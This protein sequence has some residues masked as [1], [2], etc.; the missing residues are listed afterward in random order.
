MR[1]ERMRVEL[2]P[3]KEMDAA[4]STNMEEHT[5]VRLPNRARLYYNPSEAWD[6]I[7]LIVRGAKDKKLRIRQ[8]FKKDIASITDRSRLDHVGFVTTK[9]YT[10]IV[11]K[12]NNKADN[13]W[14]SED[15]ETVVIGCDPEFVIVGDNGQAVYAD[16]VLGANG[17]NKWDKLGSDGPCAEI[18]PDP[19]E[20]IEVLIK[21]IRSLLTSNKS[22]VINNYRWI[23]GARYKHPSM[24]KGFN[25]GGHI[26]LGKPA[27]VVKPEDGAKQDLYSCQRAITRILDEIV[28]IPMIRFDTPTPAERR[29]EYGGFGD[30]RI[31]G[32]QKVEWRVPSGIWLV[33]PTF[34]RAVLSVTKAV[35]EEIW[36][37]YKDR[38]LSDAF[39]IQKGTSD[40]IYGSFGCMSDEKARSILNNS[41]IK[42]VSDQHVANIHA[43]YKKMSTYHKYKEQIDLFVKLCMSKKHPVGEKYLELRDGWVNNKQ[44]PL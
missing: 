41:S 8:A 20:D 19:S 38:D 25:I 31:K 16:T 11:N 12:N 4:A 29:K 37:R 32:P 33:H 27:D 2:R 14:V 17:N 1:E 39:M 35:T 13:V 15:T 22:E 9:T 40:N 10:A 26:H 7:Y 21:N 30:V 43:L 18:R 44:L 36:K 28:G 34:S 24:A 6:K 5:F 3:S 23:G 42:D